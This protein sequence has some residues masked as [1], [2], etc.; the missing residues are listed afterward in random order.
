MTQTRL[1]AS[2]QNKGLSDFPQRDALGSAAQRGFEAL[3]GF[4]KRLKAKPKR[5]MMHRHNKPSA[6]GI[7]HFHGLLGRA[8]GMNP[9][10]VSA[11]GIIAT[12]TRFAPEGQPVAPTGWVA[13]LLP[14]TSTE[15]AVAED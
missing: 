2:R 13:Q 1:S 11:D 9:W 8:M 5:L 3:D 15:A 14:V 4:A 10:V 6:C 7:C 12:S